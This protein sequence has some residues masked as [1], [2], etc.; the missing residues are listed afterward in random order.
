MPKHK[1]EMTGMTLTHGQWKKY[2]RWTRRR[3]AAYNNMFLYTVPSH[4]ERVAYIQGL[5]AGA[6][7]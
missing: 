5:R 6:R 7:G 1:C 3:Q 2:Q 4:M